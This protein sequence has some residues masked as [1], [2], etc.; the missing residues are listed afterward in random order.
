MEN[1]F[2]VSSFKR[3]LME[4]LIP[5]EMEE[6][7][8]TN[9]ISVSFKGDYLEG[10]VFDLAQQLNGT[11]IRRSESGGVRTLV[12]KFDPDAHL[13]FD[14]FTKNLEKYEGVTSLQLEEGSVAAVPEDE[15][16]GFMEMIKFESKAT[17]E[18][19]A[20]LKKLLDA[21]TDI[22]KVKAFIKSVV[23]GFGTPYK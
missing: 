13:K 14:I 21:N 18:Q 16:A 9:V 6:S 20:Q 19:R 17:E 12:F 10:K 11:L 2:E 8:Q 4:Y 23:G 15:Q 7:K 22:T 1:R 3:K 5:E